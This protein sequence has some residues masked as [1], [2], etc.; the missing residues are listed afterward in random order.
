MCSL[1][2]LVAA[3]L[4]SRRSQD[5][6]SRQVLDGKEECDLDTSRL[7]CHPEMKEYDLCDFGDFIC[8]EDVRYAEEGS[9]GKLFMNRRADLLSDRSNRPQLQQASRATSPQL[10]CPPFTPATRAAS[11]RVLVPALVDQ[12]P[13][14]RELRRPCP[15]IN[16]QTRDNEP[17]L[18]YGRRPP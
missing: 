6:S 1:Q 4:P 15:S 3:F 10:R 5:L 12:T 13:R 9:L 16:P 2:C 17:T 11:L 14:S 18:V 7:A 8:W